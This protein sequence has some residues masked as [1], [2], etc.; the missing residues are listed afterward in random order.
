MNLSYAQSFLDISP[1]EIIW[2]SILISLK[3]RAFNEELEKIIND[4]SPWEISF[5]PVYKEINGL[6]K[7]VETYITEY[8][9]EETLWD[10]LKSEQFSKCKQVALD[11]Y[12][13][14]PQSG[15]YRSGST[16]YFEVG[17]EFITMNFP[18]YWG[19][20]PGFKD[21]TK[22]RFHCERSWD[23]PNI[24]EWRS[25]PISKKEFIRL[26][27]DGL[28]FGSIKP[29]YDQHDTSPPNWMIISEKAIE[30]LRSWI[31]AL[32]R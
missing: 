28:I 25:E 11:T 15:D 19:K 7:D 18:E 5:S 16:F 6:K 26:V 12:F 13:E 14:N 21:G 20:V 24:S 17:G 4:F 9:P 3:N 27:F 1:D 32:D 23:W 22:G 10:I 8:I 31:E 2:E 29:K 30:P